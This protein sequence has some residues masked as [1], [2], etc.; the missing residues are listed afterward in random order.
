MKI[1]I[2]FFTKFKAKMSVGER[3]DKDCMKLNDL[4]VFFFK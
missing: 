2:F 1:Q 3:L 4:I